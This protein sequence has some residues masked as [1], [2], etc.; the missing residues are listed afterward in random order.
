MYF[1]ESLGSFILF[2]NQCFVINFSRVAYKRSAW[3]GVIKTR[4]ILTWMLPVLVTSRNWNWH[5]VESVLFVIVKILPE[6]FFLKILPEWFSCTISSY[7]SNALVHTSLQII[8]HRPYRRTDKIRLLNVIIFWT[9][10]PTKSPASMHRH[11]KQH[12]RQCY[13]NYR[14]INVFMDMISGLKDTFIRQR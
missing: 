6:Y 12:D 3:T 4:L 10:T 9:M 13:E 5:F 2:M 1:L 7:Q 11:R 14:I 8:Y